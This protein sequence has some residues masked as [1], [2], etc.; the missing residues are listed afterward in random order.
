MRNKQ[1]VPNQ[2]SLNN[3]GHVGMAGGEK[4]KNSKKTI[5]KLLKYINT[6]LATIIFVFVIAIASSALYVIS[7]KI[8]GTITT[9]VAEDYVEITKYNSL[10]KDLEDDVDLTDIGF[11]ERP[12]VNFEKIKNI[13]LFLIG[14]YILSSLLEYLQGWI[15]SSVAQKVT[16]KLRKDI[17]EKINRMPLKYF[18]NKT[19][20]DVLS[21]VT[22]DVDVLNQTLNQTLSQALTA[23]VSIVGILIMM[24]LISWQMTI[25]AL[26]ILPISM[27]LISLTVKKTQKYFAM[28]QSTLGKLNGH[29]E[30]M[31]SEHIIV[32]SFNGE[33]RSIETFKE[34]NEQLYGSAWKS[35]FLS[36]L[37]MPLMSFIGNLGYVAI[38][39]LGGY[40]GTIGRI[41]IGDIQA[42]IM[43]V[44][45]FNQP[46][47]Q[48]A[49]IVNTLQS[50]IAAAER[51][52]EFLD[53][54]D[55]IEE[56]KNPIKLEN[57]VGDVTF[58]DVM[59][60]YSPDKTVI[61]GFN[62]EVKAG[63]R[64]AIVGPTGAGKTTII[65][66]LMRFY[67]LDSGAIKIDG[68]NIIDMK[69]SDLRKM[70][71]MVLQDTWLFN[72]SI[73]DNIKYGTNASDEE[74]IKSAKVALI[75]H[76]IQSL[77]HGYDMEI[78]E[79]ASNISQGQKQLITI[80]RAML[81]NP[82]MLILDEATSS[83][84]TRTETLIQKAMD[85]LMKGRTS[86]VIAHRLSTIKDADLILVMNE[87]NIIE[88]GTH[89]ELL[90][91]K[92]FYEELYNSQFS[93]QI[94]D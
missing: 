82:P 6:Y 26:L 36:G 11:S 64:V 65:N 46:I 27:G 87:G 91:K 92:G 48:I 2:K 40:L 73:R 47:F 93:S 39:I 43:Y 71:G 83:V 70:F 78:N 80:A 76:F 75:D 28:Q 38:C 50:T 90:A 79:E 20:G 66:L 22:N 59:F 57:V 9:Q 23:I 10:T 74:M 32:K 37:M 69:R 54:E 4:P 51:I 56:S 94:E 13:A 72:G 7:P 1:F 88:K 61:K 67:D 31:Y 84:D 12:T 62:T 19:H 30:E 35:Q 63:N 77:P 29:I 3:R 8:L 25:V 86:F 68:V 16:Y 21:R 17:S 60:G 14:I 24:F 42:F 49:S 52:F 44:Q 89:K 5:S 18:D 45:R 33:K 34:S 15:M 81:A 53:E 41:S 85:T 58:E 55:E